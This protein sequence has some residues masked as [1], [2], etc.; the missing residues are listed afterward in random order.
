MPESLA[1]TTTL[2]AP[3][4]APPTSL[5]EANA[6]RL[7]HRLRTERFLA[8]LPTSV[9]TVPG[10]VDLWL[11]EGMM[12]ALHTNPLAVPVAIGLGSVLNGVAAL[13][14]GWCLSANGA[15]EHMHRA[16]PGKKPPNQLKRAFWFQT[17]AGATL[18]VFGVEQPLVVGGYLVTAAIGTAAWHI[19][20]RRMRRTLRKAIAGIPIEPAPHQPAIDTPET[21]APTPTDLLPVGALVDI[22]GRWENGVT[23][24]NKLGQSTLFNGQLHTEGRMSFFVDGGPAGLV[25]SE[26]TDAREKIAGALRLALPD[27]N[28]KGGQD[29]VFDQPGGVGLTRG[30][31]RMQVINLNSAAAKAQRA[32]EEIITADA[33]PYSVRIGGYIDDG[34]PAYWDLADHTGVWSGLITASTGLGKSAFVELLAYRAMR[35]GFHI[36]FLDPQ[37][38]ASSPILARCAT[39]PALGVDKAIPF[40][41]F[42]EDSATY[43]ESWLALH[44]TVSKILPGMVAP[45][46]PDG[47][48]PDPDCPCGGITPPPMLAYV[49]EC[50]QVFNEVFPGTNNKLGEPYGKLAKRIRKLGLGIVAVTQLGELKTFGGADLLRSNLPVRNF[51][52]MHIRSNTGGQLIPGLPYSPKLIPALPGRALSCGRSSRVMELVLDWLTHREDAPRVGGVGP[53]AEDLFEQL[54]P[55]VR[56]TADDLAANR[57]LGGGEDA[58]VVAR[59][60]A[61]E[62]VAA[63][64]A[65]GSP[66]HAPAAASTRLAAGAATTTAVPVQTVPLSW[67]APVTARCAPPTAE[68]LEA[69]YTATL[70]GRN[71]AGTIESTAEKTTAETIIWRLLLAG[72]TRK[73]DLITESRYSESQVRNAINALM[74]ARKVHRGRHGEYQPLLESK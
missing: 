16:E 31:L 48:E 73:G 24:I 6:G 64:L 60:Q 46:R 15:L 63:I 57:W 67:P 33:N 26:V 52:A 71:Q 5:A 65:G 61:R 30:Q 21:A 39:Y 7:T 53:F 34:T 70:G 19:T 13:L 32:T 44:P 41:R 72:V 10:G 49:E 20:R 1:T 17:A 54:P 58:T 18:T 9:V 12:H 38:G 62:R 25:L 47:A 35:L 74:A 42:L 50:D 68:E 2:D 55:S 40:L 28:G 27:E 4:L 23:A 45:C 3:E 36:A 37:S 59:A 29:V 8:W 22:V 11:H 69:M 51:L 43:R 66:N 14:G 56:F